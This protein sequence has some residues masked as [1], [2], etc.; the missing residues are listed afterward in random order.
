MGKMRK[1]LVSGVAT[2]PH[3]AAT[4]TPTNL[5]VTTKHKS[6]AMA[7]AAKNPNAALAQQ[8]LSMAFKSSK[9][10]GE[11]GDAE[12][13]MYELFVSVL[14]ARDLPNVELIGKTYPFAMVF[15]ASGQDPTV[16]S[17]RAVIGPNKF[18]TNV[19]AHSLNPIWE[20]DFSFH[21]RNAM[22]LQL[23][24]QV[25][26]FNRFRQ[27]TLLGHVNVS[28][29]GMTTT[30]AEQWHDIVGVDGNVAGH[31][32]IRVSLCAVQNA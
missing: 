4:D 1:E 32:Q 26:A 28:L 5:T 29:A 17:T 12:D 3:A 21:L 30:P 7:A 25:F 20:Q 8:R 2:S 24:V 6:A 9:S 18:T 15:I 10:D 22:G 16:A 11:D 14:R 31:L 19:I 27:H 13:A 23:V